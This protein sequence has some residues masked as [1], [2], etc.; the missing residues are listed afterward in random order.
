[1]IYMAEDKNNNRWNRRLMGQFQWFL[2]E[3]LLKELHLNGRL[4]TWSNERLHLTS[5]GIDRAF[6][7]NE[8]EELFPN[9]D[10]QALSSLCFDHTPLLL[11]TNNTFK[12]RKRFH[13]RR[14]W[15]KMP[16]FLETVQR[17][18][19][20]PLQNVDPFQRLD[21]LFCNMACFLKSWS[22]HC[23]GNTRTQLE[24]AKEVVLRLE[25]A[26]D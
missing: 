3:A 10:L 7:S 25:M 9:N 6:V 13:F 8:W 22:D 12:A 2:N 23:V 24:V 14:F 18:W 16:G 26:R 1:M 20:C 19:H 21:W 5:E 15:P 4:F 17:A 11:C